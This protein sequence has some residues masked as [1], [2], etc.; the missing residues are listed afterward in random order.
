M[1]KEKIKTF[2]VLIPLVAPGPVLSLFSFEGNIPNY[3]KITGE[4]IQVSNFQPIWCLI[5]ILIG[6]IVNWKVANRS[7]NTGSYLFLI[8]SIASAAT[9]YLAYGEV[10][11]VY[12]VLASTGLALKIFSYFSIC[13]LNRVINYSM[14]LNFLSMLFN[15]CIKLTMGQIEEVRLNSFG[16]NYNST[17]IIFLL[18]FIYLLKDSS[19]GSNFSTYWPLV[20]IILTGSRSVIAIS[21]IISVL[22]K[23]SVSSVFVLTTFAVIGIGIF[24]Y[25]GEVQEDFGSFTPNITLESSIIEDLGVIGRSASILVGMQ[26]LQETFPVGTQSVELSINKF[27]D[28]GYPTFAHSTVLM[29]LINLGGLGL[30]L[31]FLLIYF[32]INSNINIIISVLLIAYYLVSGGLITST[33][34]MLLTWTLLYLINYRHKPK[35]NFMTSR[36]RKLKIDG[37]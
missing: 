27:N 23:Y 30:I 25:R 21:A 34:E 20:P 4:P 28:Y 18:Y 33:K 11:D 5:M 9:A 15:F 29:L 36:I 2:L 7:F 8:L 6:L 32:L 10:G 26:I 17:G 16:L 1:I 24:K 35:I 19:R 37:R 22:K 13:E 31:I 3:Y 14:S 12:L